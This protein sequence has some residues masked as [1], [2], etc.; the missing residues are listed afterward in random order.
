MRCDV[1]PIV[2]RRAMFYGAL[3]LVRQSSL[4][5][6]EAMRYWWA[7][8]KHTYDEEIVGGCL[9]CQQRRANGSRNPFY[10]NVR[11]ASPG[12][13]IFAYHNA[14][15]RAVGVVLSRA[16]EA[17]SPFKTEE[18]GRVSTVMGWLLDVSWLELK[19]P[20]HPGQYMTILGPLLPDMHAPL[21][22]DGRGIQGGRLLEV[23]DRLAR[24]LLQL[25]GGTDPSR[26]LNPDWQPHQLRF[27]FADLEERAGEQSSTPDDTKGKE[28]ES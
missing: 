9:W 21:T 15:I 18:S 14:D 26:L 28:T 20:L 27:G 17:L 22:A 19:R 6:N 3:C 23:P 8:Q 10:E 5:H 11:L 25:A 13:V 7:N 2:S 1:F 16:R 4:E 12:D 24:A